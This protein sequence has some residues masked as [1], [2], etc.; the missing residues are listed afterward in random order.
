M[1]QDNTTE[2]NDWTK[3]KTQVFWGEIA[4]SDH[5]VQIY[6]NEEVI[7]DSLEG[8]AGSGLK[9]G[10]SVI[11]ISIENRLKA[12]NKRLGARGFNLKALKSNHQ[13][14]PLDAHEI[15]SKFI[16]LGWPNE[17]LFTKTINNIITLA[18]GKDLRKVRAYGEMVAI[19]WE[20]G[21]NGATVQL[22][23][24]WNKF[25]SQDAFCLFCAYPKS[26]FTQDAETSIEHI[27]STHSKMISGIQKSKTEVFYKGIPRNRPI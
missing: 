3:C 18:R 5:L 21:Y 13:Y 23:H 10:D 6:E 24:L 14:I 9:A 7:L 25:C 19:L 2:Q 11:I 22:E 8:F 26:G 12:L 16:R 4:P 17:E 20:Q 27:C 15:L 1:R